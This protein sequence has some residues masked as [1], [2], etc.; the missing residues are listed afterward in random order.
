MNCGTKFLRKA[1][2]HNV[3]KNFIPQN[4]ELDSIMNHKVFHNR[5]QPEIWQKCLKNI[6]KNYLNDF[7]F[8]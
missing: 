3:C 6:F 8:S 7:N 2:F 1:E 5:D 4:F